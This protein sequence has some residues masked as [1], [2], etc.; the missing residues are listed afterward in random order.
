MAA[1]VI[2]LAERSVR[3]FG[4]YKYDVCCMQRALRLIQLLDLT[5]VDRADFEDILMQLINTR[6]LSRRR[7]L[8]GVS[9]GIDYRQRRMAVDAMICCVR[10]LLGDSTTAEAEQILD[11]LEDELF[12]RKSNLLIK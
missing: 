12:Q 4:Q 11:R 1:T 9:D 7:E 5:D 6:A 3:R 2:E 10:T 8:S